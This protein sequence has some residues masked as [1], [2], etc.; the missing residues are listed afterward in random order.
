MEL[1]S[2]P[3]PQAMAPQWFV[4]MALPTLVLPLPAY[5]LFS[6]LPLLSPG[7]G[8]PAPV[9]TIPTSGP[10]PVPDPGPAPLPR[11]LCSAR[12]LC[13][14]PASQHHLCSPQPCIPL[15]PS[16]LW[17]TASRSLRTSC[18]SSVKVRRPLPAPPSP[19]LLTSPLHGTA[20]L[21][22]PTPYGR[23]RKPL[24]WCG[25]LCEEVSWVN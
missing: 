8:S 2:G 9:L 3:T 23:A 25:R 21:A 13:P 14:V 10:A 22:V 11:P 16:R 17:R 18:S 19:A 6:P 5:E 24:F 7:Q 12:T 15:P 1:G 4:A 20:A